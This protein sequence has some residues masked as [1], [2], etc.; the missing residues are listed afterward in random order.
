M[1]AKGQVSRGCEPGAAD[2][3]GATVVM[4]SDGCAALEVRRAG[5]IGDSVDHV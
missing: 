1:T 2:G 3:C 5:G 4:L